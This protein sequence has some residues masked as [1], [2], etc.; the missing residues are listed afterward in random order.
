MICE[1][2]IQSFNTYSVENR[3]RS[4]LVQDYKDYLIEVISGL[5]QDRPDDVVLRAIR[6][7]IMSVDAIEDNVRRFER[8]A[9]EVDGHMSG[10]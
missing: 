4:N 2:Y 6:S 10:R 1:P 8:L 7:T 3:R 5:I 9:Q